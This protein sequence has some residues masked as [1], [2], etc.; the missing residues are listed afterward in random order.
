MYANFYS[1][2]EKSVS[3]LSYA[4]GILICIRHLAYVDIPLP[5]LAVPSLI[6]FLSGLNKDIHFNRPLA[7]FTIILCLS[8]A[9][10]PRPDLSI[11]LQRLI[12]TIIGLC[13]FS[14]LFTNRRLTIIRRKILDTL[15]YTLAICVLISFLIWIYLLISGESFLDTIF[16]NNGFRGIFCMGMT[17]SPAAA[18]VT[19][20]AICRIF[21]S[22]TKIERSILIPIAM[23]ATIMTIAGGS[24]IALIG[25]AAGIMILAGINHKK[26]LLSLKNTTIRTITLSIVILSALLLPQA[27]HTIN[28]KTRYAIEHGSLFYSR[29]ELWQDRI[30]EFKASPLIG[31]GY[32]GLLHDDSQEFQ[33]TEIQGN[34]VTCN[35]EQQIATRKIEPGSGWLSILSYTGIIG[36]ISFLWFLTSVIC[37]EIRHPGKQLQSLSS[38]LFIFCLIN[39]L[40]EGWLLFCG[41]LLFPLFWLSCGDLNLNNHKKIHNHIKS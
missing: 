23:A 11:R 1:L 30:N 21:N 22:H 28:F 27:F 32:A 7:V 2:R 26:I 34:K 5:F 33:S 20:G 12:A 36:F 8:I 29:T 3:L 37:R 31:I 38:I 19:L 6:L 15:L 9:I 40:C 14:P 16:H 25:L 35:K 13:C 17:L 4:I 24:R 39:A 41:A 18:I 10:H